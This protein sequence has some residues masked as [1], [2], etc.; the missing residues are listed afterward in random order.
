M[1]LSEL[2][3]VQRTRLDAKRATDKLVWPERTVTILVHE[4]TLAVRQPWIGARDGL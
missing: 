4:W 1:R 2:A 3:A